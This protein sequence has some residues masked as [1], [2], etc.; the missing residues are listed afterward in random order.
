MDSL[1]TH[2]LVHYVNDS[3]VHDSAVVVEVYDK[4]ARYVSLRNFADQRL[5]ACT[6]SEKH[7]KNTW[8]W[9]EKA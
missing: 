9:P 4:D 3:G 8:H 1:T 6:Y 2:S 5:Y 7:G